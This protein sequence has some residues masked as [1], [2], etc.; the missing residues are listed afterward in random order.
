VKCVINGEDDDLKKNHLLRLG[1][2]TREYQYLS[3]PHPLLL[4][5]RHAGLKERRMM[6]DVT[7]L[8]TQGTDASIG[9]CIITGI[10]HSINRRGLYEPTY[11]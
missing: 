9:G 2:F 10:A 1:K 8:T 4:C 3:N 11:C 5:A 7:V 6:K